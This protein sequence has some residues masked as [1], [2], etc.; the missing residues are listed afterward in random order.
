MACCR[1]GDGG[2]LTQSGQDKNRG[3][4]GS[5]GRRRGQCGL[6]SL[7]ARAFRRAVCG[8]ASRRGSGDSYLELTG[9]PQEED[10]GGTVSHHFRNNTLLKLSYLETI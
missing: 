1:A 4:G 9:R 7:V 2:Q 6:C 10:A 3:N 8:A 5:G